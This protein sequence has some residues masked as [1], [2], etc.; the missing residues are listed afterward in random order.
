MALQVYLGRRPA[1]DP[2]VG[3]DEGQVLALLVGEAGPGRRH[4]SRI[5]FA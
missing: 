1:I 2:S 5:R 4:P 3:V